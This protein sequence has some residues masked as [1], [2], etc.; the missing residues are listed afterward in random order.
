MTTYWTPSTTINSDNLEEIATLMNTD[1]L[2]QG[3]HSLMIGPETHA[4]G[5]EST[6]ADTSTILQIGSAESGEAS[7]Q[8][9]G[10]IWRIGVLLNYENQNLYAKSFY[11]LY[12][13]NEIKVGIPVNFG[14]CS[15]EYI[16]DPEEAE[17]WN[18]PLI[19]G[20]QL[21][22]TWKTHLLKDEASTS[23]YTD[24]NAP[25]ILY[26]EDL[27]PGFDVSV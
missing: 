21:L 15:I 20:Q 3:I 2:W 6:V 12:I 9:N 1:N 16:V 27:G 17:L 26:I 5:G 24:V 11:E 25:L 8:Y 22:V 4:T 23:L 10:N 19:A 13:N 7:I 18:E 14:Q